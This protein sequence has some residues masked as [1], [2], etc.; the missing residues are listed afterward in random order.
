[1]T[2]ETHKGLDLPERVRR[3]LA[4][5]VA[6]NG[7]QARAIAVGDTGSMRPPQGH[8]VVAATQEEIDA[9]RG[10]ARILRRLEFYKTHYGPVVRLAI[11]IY[12]QSGGEPLSAGSLLNVSQASGDVALAGLG[13][14]KTLYTHFYYVVDDGGDL[15][16]AFSKEIPNVPEQ[17]TEAK[18]V[19]KMARDAYSGTPEERR[20][21]RWAVGLAEKQFELPVPEPD[22]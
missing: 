4:A 21:F 18:K 6:S 20:S 1:L 11:S 14:Q 19:L 17:R 3:S 2:E 12:P 15:T 8:V 5:A 16:Y 13:R 22:E 10:P 7:V 9:V